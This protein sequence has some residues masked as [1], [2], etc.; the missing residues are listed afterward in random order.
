MTTYRVT[1]SGIVVERGLSPSGAIAA[2][3]Q[4]SGHGPDFWD[5]GIE[6]TMSDLL[7]VTQAAA[8]IGVDES[9]VRRYIR[10]NR[11]PHVAIS[12]RIRLVRRKDAQ[13]FAKRSRPVGRPKEEGKKISA[14]KSR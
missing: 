7:T 9:L 2:W 5:V 8:L 1:V 12:K 6:L 10:E 11:L 3:E 13:A 14:K 4:W